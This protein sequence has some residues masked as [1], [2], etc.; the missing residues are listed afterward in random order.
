MNMKNTVSC[1]FGCGRSI[2]RVKH[3]ALP[4]SYLAPRGYETTSE[5]DLRRN[6][7]GAGHDLFAF[8]PAFVFKFCEA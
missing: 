2:S 6:V 4:F 1:L 3:L 8:H 7:E 5:I